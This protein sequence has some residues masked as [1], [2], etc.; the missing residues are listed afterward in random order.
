MN[1]IMTKWLCLPVALLLVSCAGA[2]YRRTLNI[3]TSSFHEEIRLKKKHHDLWFDLY[4]EE[5]INA[6]ILSKAWATNLSNNT[7]KTDYE[8]YDGSVPSS[9]PCVPI[10]RKPILIHPGQRELF[11]SGPVDT[12]GMSFS[13]PPQNGAKLR[14]DVLLE[15]SPTKPLIGSFASTWGGP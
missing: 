13:E 9:G 1:L 6:R 10:H 15:K 14:I 5:S 2:D 7:I 12:L 11:Y 8:V 3:T 4:N